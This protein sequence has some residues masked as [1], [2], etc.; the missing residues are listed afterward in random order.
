MQGHLR[1]VSDVRK[2][3]LS[4]RASNALSCIKPNPASSPRLAR[5]HSCSIHPINLS[6][7]SPSIH[8]CRLCQCIDRQSICQT[9]A[10]SLR[11]QIVRS[12]ATGRSR[13]QVHSQRSP[14][15]TSL[16]P[17][18]YPLAPRF[19]PLRSVF[20]S[21][22]SPRVLQPTGEECEQ[23]LQ[24]MEEECERAQAAAGQKGRGPVTMKAGGG[25]A[26]SASM[27]SGCWGRRGRRRS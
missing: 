2:R 1:G 9:L 21:S 11:L 18:L 27:R 14:S 16:S 26:S 5:V 6:I 22:P 15:S 17:C 7:P 12:D 25:A 24:K 8:P 23:A 4:R 3:E 19:L 13:L 20:L 10:P